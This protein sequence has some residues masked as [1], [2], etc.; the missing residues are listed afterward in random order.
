MDSRVEPGAGSWLPALGDS[1]K[2]L[3]MG[4]LM[5]KAGRRRWGRR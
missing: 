5:R 3:Q 4:P 2:N 1:T